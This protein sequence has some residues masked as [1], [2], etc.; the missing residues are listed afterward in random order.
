MTLNALA[1]NATL[2]AL[3]VLIPGAMLEGGAKC[4]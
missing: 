1:D 2:I 3:G 4:R